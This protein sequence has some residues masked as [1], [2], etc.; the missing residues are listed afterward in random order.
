MAGPP[1]SARSFAQWLVACTF[2]I[3]FVVATIVASFAFAQLSATYALGSLAADMQD[4]VIEQ[5]RERLARADAEA[6]LV[7]LPGH[8]CG[9]GERCDRGLDRYLGWPFGAGGELRCST[10]LV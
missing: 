1:A 3:S 2:T 7:V 5:V 10:T 6:H 4:S 9:A 8:L